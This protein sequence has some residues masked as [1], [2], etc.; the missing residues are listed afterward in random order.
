MKF[1]QN[2][3]S[4]FSTFYTNRMRTFLIVL[5]ISI[6]IAGVIVMM[7]LGAGAQKLVMNE[8]E[9]VGGPLT[10]GVYRPDK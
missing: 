8:V 1:V 9:K 6:G 4:A 7:S 10:F 5:S 3:Y 2:T